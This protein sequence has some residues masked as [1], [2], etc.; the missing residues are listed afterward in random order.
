MGIHPKTAILFVGL[1][2]S[3]AFLLLSVLYQSQTGLMFSIVFQLLPVLATKGQLGSR[4]WYTPLWLA[5][6]GGAFL[7]AGWFQ[8]SEG[9]QVEP[10]FRSFGPGYLIMAVLALFWPT[11]FN[12]RGSG[13]VQEG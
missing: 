3:S 7:V 6:S 8:A 11:W 4:R 13:E 1:I 2:L 5:W 12:S 10:V 9:L